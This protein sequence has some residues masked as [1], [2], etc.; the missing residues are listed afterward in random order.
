MTIVEAA[1]YNYEYRVLSPT[2]PVHKQ[3]P[4]YTVSLYI[5]G[6]FE[7]IFLV[8]HSR[9][10]DPWLENVFV[11]LWDW[12]HSFS[13]LR[14]RLERNVI[15]ISWFV[16]RSNSYRNARIRIPKMRGMSE[17]NISSVDKGQANQALS[18]EALSRR[19]P[20]YRRRR[21]VF[22][23]R[24]ARLVATNRCVVDNQRKI[25]SVTYVSSSYYEQ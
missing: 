17:R 22:G 16:R 4:S 23:G 10:T 19:L 2:C 13:E 5:H 7:K 18:H 25:L 20:W 12:P 1:D 14:F 11:H 15:G 21:P 3:F 8:P 24:R 9:D 6:D